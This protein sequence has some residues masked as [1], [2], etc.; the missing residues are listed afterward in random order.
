MMAHKS[1]SDRNIA[2]SKRLSAK[3]GEY[4]DK[5]TNQPKGE[6]TQIGVILN[7]DNGEYMLLDP[8]VSLSGVL[9]KQNALAFKNNKPMRDSV[10]VGVYE[11]NSNQ[12]QQSNTQGSYQQQGGY[13]QQQNQQ[14]Q[15]Q[16][17]APQQG[18]V[19]QGQQQ[20]YQ[21]QG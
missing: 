6:Y 12:G 7:G 16:Q 3:T 21:K 18:Y 5:Q 17:Q 10:M 14:G 13:Q 1:I 4:I 9:Q 15:Y 2:M 8:S 11:E 20:G 19:Q